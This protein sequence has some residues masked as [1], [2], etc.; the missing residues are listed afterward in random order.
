MKVQKK[1]LV[2]VLA[3]FAGAGCSSGGDGN[4]AIAGTDLVVKGMV[5]S[6]GTDG[7][8][9]MPLADA[10]VQL[11]IDADGDG[12]IAAS[13]RVTATADEAGNYEI[14]AKVQKG[15]NVVVSF[16]EEGYAP[17]FRRVVAGPKAEMVL[18]VALA[19]LEP[20]ECEGARCAMEGNRLSIKGLREGLAGS[21]RVFNP[22]T[23]THL[24]PGGF[25][26]SDGNL[27]ISGVFSAVQLQDES[28]AEL[29]Q[30]EEDV[31]LRMQM[32]Q[33]T[34]PVIVDLQ[35]DNDRID[36]PLYAFDE[37]KGTWVRHAKDGWLEDGSGGIIPESELAS[38]RGGTW[39]G[40][41]IATGEV[42]HF[43][44]WNVDWPVESHG[45]IEGLIRDPDGEIAEGA[46]VTASGRTYTGTSASQTTGDDGRFALD[47]MRSEGS[48]D[49]DQDGTPGETHRIALRVVHGGKV[50]DA[51]EFDAPVEP[52]SDGENCGDVGI[53]ELGP[54]KE[55]VAGVCSLHGTIVDEQGQPLEGVGVYA[56][57][58]TVP[59]EVE[60]ALCGEFYENCQYWA[61]TDMDG[62]WQAS[63]AVMDLVTVW[64]MHSWESDDGV[65][66]L[67]YG[68]TSR[69]GCPPDAITVRL[70]EGWDTFELTLT[71]G[72][73]Q[74][75]WSPAVNASQI[76]V[77]DAGGVPKWIVSTDGE[78]DPGFP[79]PVTYG[80][81]PA[82][83]VVVWPTDGSAP[84][85]LASGD[86]VQVASYRFG[87]T[88]IWNWAIGSYVVP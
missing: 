52:G 84:A 47:V 59:D 49:V 80:T 39:T 82:G 53:I 20:L 75:A 62:A 33:D 35:P 22:V 6:A 10:Q 56:W 4:G 17:I 41:I 18:N 15:Q 54:E 34:W 27:L 66:H 85:P 81:T 45:C 40:V 43:S 31:E 76:Y 70:T 55:L 88:G 72:E 44:Y 16:S 51:G 64:G 2:G 23:E 42:N 61:S 71:V 32:P 63:A 29:H 69:L 30:L 57:D 8:S 14:G 65:S 67:R 28:G 9:G 25:D 46:T 21:A 78:N 19:S 48:D 37:A 87:A 68:N 86:T 11:T 5:S 73:G 77:V 36:I 12:K 79:S 60:M 13:E 24:F 74:I 26:D 1:L 83:A 38:I 50:Y 3:A 58:D 7:T